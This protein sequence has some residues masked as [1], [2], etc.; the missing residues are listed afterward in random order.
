MASWLQSESA[1]STM[2]VAIVGL[3]LLEVFRNN[4]AFFNLGSKKFESKFQTA[5]ERAR[6]CYFATRIVLW[7]ST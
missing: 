4:F 1:S 3:T 7:N 2:V 5:D 6:A